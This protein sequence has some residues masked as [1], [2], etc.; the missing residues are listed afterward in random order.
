MR[1][2]KQ[3]SITSHARRVFSLVM[4]DTFICSIVIM[5]ST[6]LESW[7]KNAGRENIIRLINSISNIKQDHRLL[8]QMIYSA[9]ITSHCMQ[10]WFIF[11]GVPSRRKTHHMLQISN[12]ISIH[13]IVSALG[14]LKYIA[15][16]MSTGSL[17]I[18][19]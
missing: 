1:D 10:I 8:Y 11:Y 16:R 7:I 4:V 17:V 18:A 15:L 2:V 9:F 5:Y 3:F 6:V 13:V 19:S 12:F 14:F